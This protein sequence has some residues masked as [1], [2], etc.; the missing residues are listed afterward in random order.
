LDQLVDQG[1]GFRTRRSANLLHTEAFAQVILG[2]GTLVTL[3]GEQ[4][5]EVAALGLGHRLD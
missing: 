1:R 4:P 2:R 5:E 3:S